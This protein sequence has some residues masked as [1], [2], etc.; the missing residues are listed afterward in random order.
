MAAL[1]VCGACGGGGDGSGSAGTVDPPV[2]HVPSGNELAPL[3]VADELEPGRPRADVPEVF[4]QM[5]DH[6]AARRPT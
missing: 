5:A 6:R 4:Q 1:L 3:L 2:P